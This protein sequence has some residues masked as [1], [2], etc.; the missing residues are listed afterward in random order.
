MVWWCQSY[1][2]D[3]SQSVLLGLGIFFPIF[4][5]GLLCVALAVLELPL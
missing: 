5:M 2:D 1:H 4:M 3:Q